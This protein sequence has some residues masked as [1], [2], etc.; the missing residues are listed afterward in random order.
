MDGE[1]Y[2]PWHVTAAEVAR[3]FSYAR[4]WEMPMEEHL[5]I[6]R[7]VGLYGEP[8][9]GMTHHCAEGPLRRIW[10]QYQAAEGEY[11]HA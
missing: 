2:D 7:C 5:E 10:E 8:A 4:I 3:W 9:C 6:A 1:V 11:P